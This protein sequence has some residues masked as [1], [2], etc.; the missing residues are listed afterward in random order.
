MSNSARRWLRTWWRR[1]Q[2]RAYIRSD[3][4]QARRMVA[5]AA[6]GWRCQRCGARNDLEVHHRSYTHFGCERAE[7]LEVLCAAHHRA[8]DAQRVAQ[9]GRRR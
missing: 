4:W 9:N 5:L 7:E 3:A 6:A 8:A 2:Y 1:R